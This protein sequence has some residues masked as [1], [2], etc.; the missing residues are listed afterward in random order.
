MTSSDAFKQVKNNLSPYD[1]VS[2]LVPKDTAIVN[3]ILQTIAQFELINDASFL[4]ELTPQSP[5]MQNLDLASLKS[6]EGQSHREVVSSSSSTVQKTFPLQRRTKIRQYK[7]SHRDKKSAASDLNSDEGAN[8][9]EDRI[10]SLFANFDE[11]KRKQHKRFVEMHE[12]DVEQLR[13]EQIIDG[14]HLGENCKQKDKLRQA[15]KGSFPIFRYVPSRVTM[16]RIILRATT[17]PKDFEG[18]EL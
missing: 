10:A 12:K 2:H 11:I 13:D 7:P 15:L 8:K 6:E 18:F 4:S 3:M 9:G 5:E 14:H 1:L 16:Q 17:L